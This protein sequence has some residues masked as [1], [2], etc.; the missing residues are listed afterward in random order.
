MTTLLQVAL[1]G[2]LGA[3]LR[4]LTTFASGRLFGSAFPWGTIVVNVAGS[5]A[6]GALAV[7]LVGRGAQAWSPFLVTGLL[8]GFTTF[9]AFSLDAASLV[10]R[11]V[12]GVAM[13]YVAASVALSLIGVAAGLWAGRLV[14]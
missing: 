5:F 10:E 3:V 12:P 6:I 14:A 9:S 11:G 4:F 13:A 7:V 2:A 1:G 8:G